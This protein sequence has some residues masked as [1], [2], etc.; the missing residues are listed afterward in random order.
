M[1]MPIAP[2]KKKKKKKPM[3]DKPGKSLL[4]TRELI[5]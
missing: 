5:T 3:W 1:S 4:T 2:L